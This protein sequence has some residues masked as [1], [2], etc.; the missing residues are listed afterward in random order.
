MDFT[1]WLDPDL[2]EDASPADLMG[3]VLDALKNAP[4]VWNISDQAS[5]WDALGATGR[6]TTPPI[7]WTGEFKPGR[8]DEQWI[9]WPRSEATDSPMSEKE[10]DEQIDWYLRAVTSEGAD[11]NQRRFDLESLAAIITRNPRAGYGR[12]PLDTDSH[13]SDCLICEGA[14]DDAAFALNPPGLARDGHPYKDTVN[15]GDPVYV[16]DQE[17]ATFAFLWEPHAKIAFEREKA[18]G[19]VNLVSFTIK[20]PSAV[21]LDT[22][23]R[24]Y[25]EAL[26]D[27]ACSH[28]PEKVDPVEALDSAIFAINTL[29]HPDASAAGDVDTLEAR[30]A[31][32]R[33][34]L[35]E[36]REWH[37]ANPEWKDN[38]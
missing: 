5:S 32:I 13:D 23:K 22:T 26:A 16:V 12:V 28:G 9:A 20:A 10:D 21:A 29:M 3:F 18:I 11:V 2:P 36:I 34:R 6:V 31:E 1:L 14:D 37:V 35:H 8:D 38:H 30:E 19:A 7:D 4:L 33:A 15:V 25:V 27:Y 17:G 24:R